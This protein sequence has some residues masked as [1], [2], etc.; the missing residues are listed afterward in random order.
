MGAQKKRSAIDA[1]SVLV[2]TVQESWEEEKLAGALFMDVKGAFDHVSRS[3][4]L[5]RMVEL[6]IDGDLVAWTR[7][8]LT[9]RKI[10]LLL[11]GMKIKRER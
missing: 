4:L 7:S 3:Q 8:F 10:R 11:T 6:G 5:K 1:V 9:G 2:H